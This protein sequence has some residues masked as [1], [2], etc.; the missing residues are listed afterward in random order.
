M[1]PRLPKRDTLVKVVSGIAITVWLV[2]RHFFP[3]ADI[4]VPLIGVCWFLV[5][6]GLWTAFHNA[7]M[8]TSIPLATTLFGAVLMALSVVALIWKSA[9]EV[10]LYLIVIGFILFAGWRGEAYPKLLRAR[11]WGAPVR[12]HV[13]FAIMPFL[14]V[15]PPVLSFIFGGLLVGSSI[16]LLVVPLTIWK[17]RAMVRELNNMD[18][19]S[20]LRA[21]VCT[22]RETGEENTIY[23]IVVGNRV[24]LSATQSTPPTTA[25]P[26]KIVVAIS[27]DA[28]LDW[29]A[30][31]FCEVRTHTSHPN[32]RKKGDYECLSW[33]VQPFG[34]RPYI[35]GMS[36]CPLPR[37]IY[38]EFEELIQA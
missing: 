16:F 6:A 19:R 34:D 23:Y 28:D 18:M 26:E 13:W 29:T 33:E 35:D 24:Y 4:L 31:Q 20:P 37:D 15:L 38:H 14:I 1:V 25:F 3:N 11:R 22:L 36:F 21:L 30:Y 32:E 9:P 12:L 8:S 27:E 2:A 10:Q 7:R 17:H 5:G